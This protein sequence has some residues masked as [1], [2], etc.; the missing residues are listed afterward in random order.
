MAILRELIA[1]AQELT[2]SYAMLG[3]R[4]DVKNALSITLYIDFD[5]DDST[6]ITIKP[7]GFLS[8]QTG[9]PA[10]GAFDLPQNGTVT[11]GVIEFV[12]L[13]FEVPAAGGK[14]AITVNT[15]YGVPYVGFQV[16]AG[17]VGGNAGEVLTAEY[18]LT[19]NL[20]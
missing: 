18:N 17:T 9:S 2:S 16:K 14:I 8:A 19:D 3:E 20:Q 4:V 6:D 10:V 7:V 5:V 12:P 13:V 11:G 15:S 1:E